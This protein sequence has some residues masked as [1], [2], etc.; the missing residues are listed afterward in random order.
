MAIRK[1]RELRQSGMSR[2]IAGL[3]LEKD[4][5]YIAIAVLEA[6]GKYQVNKRYSL[7]YLER[8]K[9]DSYSN[10]MNRILEL[11]NKNPL[12]DKIGLVVDTGCG[13]PL[14]D[15]LIKVHPI[16][17]VTITEDDSIIRDI[18][19]Y[20]VSKKELITNLQLLFIAERL[21][22]NQDLPLAEVFIKKLL[23]FRVKSNPQ[24][25][26]E[27]KE[28]THNDLV[29]AVALACWYGQEVSESKVKFRKP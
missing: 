4:R 1:V 17:A 5:D 13:Q 18:N 24:K 6:F 21:R 11:V 16:I 15:M 7:R 27:N 28:E 8:F 20:R 14:I 19:H 3:A 12:K 23:S 29:F 25:T 26:H 2:F 22:V 9:E 10:V